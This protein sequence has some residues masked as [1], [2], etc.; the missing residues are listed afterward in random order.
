MAM[1]PRLEL[2]QTQTLVMTLQLQQAIKLL[3]LSNL[4]LASFVEAE[5][6]K[7]PLLEH[8][9][10]DGDDSGSNGEAE[11]DGPDKDG[12]ADL[13]LVDLSDGG[14]ASS[15]IEA[16]LDVDYEN[17]YTNDTAVD[18]AVDATVDA[19]AGMSGHIPGR[20]GSSSFFDPDY[21]IENTVKADQSL[22]DHLMDQLSLNLANPS[23]KI[24]GAH[25]IDLLDDAG[26]LP[27][28]L[29]SVAWTLNCDPA[30][31]EATVKVL[32]TFDPTGVFARGLGECLALQLKERDRLDPAM[33]A[34]LTHLDLVAKGDIAGLK[35]IC[36]VDAEDIADMLTEIRALNPKPGLSFGNEVTQ[37]LIPDVFVRRNP[38]GGWLVEL[39]NETLPRVLV[40]MHYY[41]HVNGRAKTSEEKAY[42]SECLSSAN[43]LVKS[44]N[45][46]ANTILR[47]ATELVR[48]QEDFLEHG[49]RKLKPLNLRAV[50]EAI[51]MHESTVSRVTSN[52]F[53]ATPR[54]IF[55]LKYFFTTAIASA[56]GGDAHSAE[57][58]RDRIKELVENESPD[59]ILSDDR[60]VEI[61]RQSGINIARRT[62]AKYR[63]ILHIQSSVQRR[64]NAKM[65][66]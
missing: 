17:V 22:R 53:M 15:A 14:P 41:A 64:R 20:A 51:E 10:D 8:A 61:L 16:A 60:I 37:T 30:E 55:E 47:V 39:N 38:D 42:L 57:S 65:T 48:Q 36:G 56:E 7:N 44:L 46:R 3:Q 52:K 62:V 27:A 25:L 24:I 18:A 66:A 21:N 59:D 4:E 43:W 9:D 35:R 11:P 58:V 33:Q 6:E 19:S 32:Q 34:L 23:Q 50:A 5:L 54:G 13:R 28:D 63:E 40:N 2:R 31:V 45:Q 49:V 12:D 26:Y 1:T 29:S